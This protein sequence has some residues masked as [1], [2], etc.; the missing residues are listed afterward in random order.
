MVRNS[1]VEGVEARIN[2]E[3]AKNRNLAKEDYSELRRQV[4]EVDDNNY[5]AP[6][7]IPQTNNTTTTAARTS[8]TALNWT[9]AEG[10]VF[11]RLAENL[12]DNPACFNN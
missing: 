6:E 1:R 5:P 7:N 12:P 4:I 3:V 8:E 10:I 9:G 11:P 2:F